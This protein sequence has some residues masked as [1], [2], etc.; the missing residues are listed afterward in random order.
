MDPIGYI[1]IYPDNLTKKPPFFVIFSSILAGTGEGSNSSWWASRKGVGRVD[2]PILFVTACDSWLLVSLALTSFRDIVGDQEINLQ[3]LQW[4]SRWWFQIFLILTRKIGEM[5]QFDEH[6][7]ADG[8]FNHH[9]V[10]IFLPWAFV[11]FFFS[12]LP[13]N[14]W[15]Y[16][17]L[18]M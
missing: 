2:S 15:I 1:I 9:L 14:T 3:R 18:V 4:C 12:R 11:R 13:S 17:M 16:S 10:V 8:W 6:I 7:F 5:I